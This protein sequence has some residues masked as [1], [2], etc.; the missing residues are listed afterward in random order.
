[1][2]YSNIILIVQMHIFFNSE[3]ICLPLKWVIIKRNS[4]LLCD[5]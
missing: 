2:Y 4:C 3:I 5:L 1:M